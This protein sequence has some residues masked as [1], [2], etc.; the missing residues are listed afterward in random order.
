MV[1]EES[2]IKQSIENLVEIIDAL[3][4]YIVKNAANLQPW[5]EMFLCRHL[6]ES[7]NRLVNT[8]LNDIV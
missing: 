3:H 5:M 8:H 2:N 4:Y 1:E 6:A 7:Q